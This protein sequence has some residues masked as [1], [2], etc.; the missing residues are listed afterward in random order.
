MRS[1][2][3]SIVVAAGLALAACGGGSS[4]DQGAGTAGTPD[5]AGDGGSSGGE[6]SAELL[7]FQAETVDG[8]TVDLGDFAGS[9][10]VIWFWA[11]W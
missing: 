10:L 4:S 6:A 3:T 5:A 7:S 1:R 2:L 8:T 9:D 11:P